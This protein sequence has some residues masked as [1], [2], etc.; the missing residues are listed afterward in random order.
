MQVD[1]LSSEPPGKPAREVCPLQ[2]LRDIHNS[3]QVATQGAQ[4]SAQGEKGPR[5]CAFM[6]IFEWGSGAEAR[7]AHLNRKSKALVSPSGVIS[8]G[9]WEPQEMAD[10]EGRRMGQPQQDFR[11]LETLESRAHAPSPPGCP[12]LAQ[13]EGTFP[14][15]TEGYNCA[16][17][18]DLQGQRLQ[19]GRHG[20]QEQ[21]G[22]VRFQGLREKR[23]LS[24]PSMCKAL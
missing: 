8:K 20:R 22:V 5:A 6:G 9:C 3:P 15:D 24:G 21:P 1:F 7:S 11:L 12:E 2:V 17:R 4:G 16:P 10:L 13:R 18:T 19:K 14:P 23:N